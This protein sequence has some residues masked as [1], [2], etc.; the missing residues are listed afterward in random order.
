MSESF[1]CNY[2]TLLYVIIFST[3][4]RQ[5]K[6]SGWCVK[7]TTPKGIFFLLHLS[8][9]MQYFRGFRRASQS[10]AEASYFSILPWSTP[11][12]Y[13]HTYSHIMAANGRVKSPTI[14][15]QDPQ[16]VDPPD[17]T[18]ILPH[19]VTASCLLHEFQRPHQPHYQADVNCLRLLEWVRTHTILV[20][21]VGAWNWYCA[22]LMWLKSWG[23]EIVVDVESS[24]INLI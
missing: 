6:A 7:D 23:F 10:A 13:P 14:V 3:E 8:Y 5:Q 4:T 20:W 16:F 18:S 15:D 12:T 17:S 21:S 24:N 9:D 1:L 22:Q 2:L 11:I 19:V